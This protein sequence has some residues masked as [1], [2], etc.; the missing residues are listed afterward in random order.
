MVVFQRHDCVLELSSRCLVF[1]HD[2][3]LSERPG[4][5]AVSRLIRAENHIPPFALGEPKVRPDETPETGH[6]LI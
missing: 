1:E 3:E 6:E 5:L 4:L 2:V